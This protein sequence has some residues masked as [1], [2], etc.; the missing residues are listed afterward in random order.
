MCMWVYFATLFSFQVCCCS[1]HHHH[2]E[3]G[4]HFVRL[5]VNAYSSCSCCCYCGVRDDDGVVLLCCCWLFLCFFFSLKKSIIM[6]MMKIFCFCFLGTV[7][8]KTY[9]NFQLFSLVVIQKSF[10]TLQFAFS[11]SFFLFW[12]LRGGL[13]FYGEFQTI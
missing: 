1:F 3:H 7:V 9:K 4:T 12:F 2:H 10:V 6:L 13:F 5:L 11:V 8:Y